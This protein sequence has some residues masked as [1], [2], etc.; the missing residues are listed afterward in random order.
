MHKTTFA[1]KARFCHPPQAT[2]QGAVIILL[3][4]SLV[5]LLGFAGLALDSG[6]AYGVR[7][8]LSAATDAAAI[9]AARALP[10]GNT[11]AERRANAQIAANRYFN[12]NFP[13]GTR[14][15]TVGTPATTVQR[16]ANGTW[17]IT[18]DSQAT[19]PNTLMRVLGINDTPV[20]TRGQTVRVSPDVM[21][22]LDSSGSIGSDMPL[23]KSAAKTNFV[24]RFI[25]GAGG[26]R[27]GLV[28]FAYGSHVNE[29]IDRGTQGGFDKA[30]IGSAID[31][32]SASGRTATSE[33]IR[34]A[35]DELQAIPV[36]NRSSLRVMLVFSDGAPNVFG[37]EM[38]N[39]SVRR[40]VNVAGSLNGANDIDFTSPD[41]LRSTPITDL[42]GFV[43]A[44]RTSQAQLPLLGAGNV[45]LDGRRSLGA[46][47]ADD[48]TRNRAARN[49]MENTAAQARSE[50]IRVYTIG[51]GTRLLTP[52]VTRCGYGDEEK[53]ENLLKRV[54]NV[55]NVDTFNPAHPKGLY[56]FAPDA[57][58]LDE[59]F[60][61]IAS[62]IIRLTL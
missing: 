22:V 59:C 47:S 12:L 20:T 54:A 36:A 30:A 42:A 31:G 46:Y 43:Y 38:Q 6:R 26:D 5:A 41:V 52:E 8:Q 35:Y 10:D 32:M 21:M 19:M 33:G 17:R 56:C 61:Q 18:V 51:L 49:M 50:G 57:S 29:A 16:E 4:V 48:C 2:Q 27:L 60:D 40:A 25:A 7:A 34:K 28:T 55:E 11:E 39:G 58:R 1:P 53:G 37:A 14:G 45:P 9:A 15:T 13:Q 3:A 24:D 44:G 23:L 62:D